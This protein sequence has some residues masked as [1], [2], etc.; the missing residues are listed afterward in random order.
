MGRFFLLGKTGSVY[1]H[2][3]RRIMIGKF[4]LPAQGLWD[5]I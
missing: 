5:K 3:S 2:G 1:F 4:I